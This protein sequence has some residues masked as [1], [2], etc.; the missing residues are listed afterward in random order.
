MALKVWLP[1]NGDL[2]N[3]G[4]SDNIAYVIASGNSFTSGG[5]ISNNALKLTKIQQILGTTSCMTGAKEI[6]Y[7]FW[8]KVNTAWST[9]WLDGIRWISTNGTSTATERQE[10]YTNCT[11]I[12]TWYKGGAIYGKAFTPEIWTHLAATI[13]YNTGEACFYI[14]GDLKGTTSNVDTTYYCRGDFYIGDNGVDILQN[15]VRIYDHCLS[16]KEV[17]EISQ[18]LILH[19][20]LNGWSGGV[21]ENLLKGTSNQLLSASIAQYY[22]TIGQESTTFW[23]LNAGDIATYSI[24]LK[25]P[26]DKKVRARIQFF[27]SDSDRPNIHGN[28]IE[29]GKEG[30]STITW[31]MTSTQRAYSK[32]QLFV[33]CNDGTTNTNTFYYKEVKLEK[34]STATPWMPAPADLGID[35][36]KITDSSGYGNNGNI[37]NATIEN[38]NLDGRYQICTNFLGTTVDSTSN[39]I[40]GAQYLY[41]SLP[42]PA[43]SALT[44]AWWGNNISYGRG[45]IFETTGTTGN[46][47]EGNDY[48]TTAIANWDSTFGI[49]NGSTRVNIFNNFVKDSS[50]HYHA[51][52]FDGANVKYYCDDTLKQ[53]SALTGTLPAITGFKMGL[54]RAGGVYRQIKQKVSDLRIY[55]TALSAEDILD[56]YHTPANI[57]NLGNAHAFEF[58]QD[59]DT[60]IEKN[61]IFRNRWSEGLELKTLNDG[62]IWAKLYYFDYD[63]AGTIWTPEEAKWCNKK[64]KYS[65][66]GDLEK[67]IPED[68]WYEFWY[69]EK[70]DG[71]QFIRWKQSYNPLSRVTSGAGGTSS[72]YQFISGTSRGSFTG[73]TRYSADDSSSCYLRGVAAWWGAIAPYQTSYDVFPTMWGSSQTGNHHQELWINITNNAN[74]SRITK[75]EKSICLIEK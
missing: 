50:W 29:A 38:I 62:S 72:E 20:K 55:V 14:N 25:A 9:D 60:K 43:W 52:T 75:D 54:G 16:S 37:V 6:S 70:K 56:L 35:T 22:T 48:N 3:K 7:A 32:M 18:G 27:N 5:K 42:M 8:V 64:A 63:D 65:C 71:S 36:T 53:T 10:F 39:T 41:T 44:L 4:I 58:I 47:W 61:G 1:L 24:Y 45:G 28:Y 11:L 13:N 31:T 74:I 51:I 46:I 67:F 12:G 68:G 17:K 40:T 66:L 26:S 19:Y 69:T 57:D 34:G 73:L 49:Y 21:G 23:G 33:D 30:Y 2:E 15:D 59:D